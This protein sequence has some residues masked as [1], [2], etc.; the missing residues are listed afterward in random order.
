[1]NAL[2]LELSIDTDSKTRQ[3]QPIPSVTE[4]FFVSEIQLKGLSTQSR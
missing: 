1:M 2:H 3:C 4:L